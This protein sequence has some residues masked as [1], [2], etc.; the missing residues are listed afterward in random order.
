LDNGVL[1]EVQC[2]PLYQQIEEA[3][4]L[5]LGVRLKKAVVGMSW[6]F[7]NE[8][9]PLGPEHEAFPPNFVPLHVG[10]N[11]VVFAEGS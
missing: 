9:E 7:Y 10:S 3:F 4:S 8:F 11:R 1:S 2:V 6:I 5:V